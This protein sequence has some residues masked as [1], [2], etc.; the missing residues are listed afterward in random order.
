MSFV[1]G[2]V[3]PPAEGQKGRGVGAVSPVGMMGRWGAAPMGWKPWAC[4]M[5]DQ[6]ESGQGR[7]R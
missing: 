4:G 5:M 3:Q 7:G 1:G 6:P 2:T